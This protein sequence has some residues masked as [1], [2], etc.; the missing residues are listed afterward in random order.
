MNFRTKL[1][2]IT[3]LPITLISLAALWLIDS[4]SKKLAE[5][6]GQAVE[7]MIVQSKQI[8]LQNY[9]KLARAAVEPFY[10]WDNVSR[11]QAQKQVAEVIT[12]PT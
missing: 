10:Q 12:P 8:E 1:L 7:N 11:L 6:Q 5:A 2:A 4:Q 9:I 3:I